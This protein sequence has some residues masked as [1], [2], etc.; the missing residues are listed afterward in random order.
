MSRANSFRGEA[1]GGQFVEFV[2]V[3]RDDDR[4]VFDRLAYAARVL[5]LL[6]PPG[7]TVAVCPGTVRLVVREGQEL[8]NPT[9]ARWALVSVPPDASRAHIAL[10]LA[11]LAGR[12]NDPFLLEVLLRLT[13]G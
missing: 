2:R 9:R 5:R 1:D 10:T 6:A 12:A 8:A 11:R 13:P 3:D 7:L 4:E